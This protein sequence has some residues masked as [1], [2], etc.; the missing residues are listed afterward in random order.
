MATQVINTTFKLKRGIASRWMELNPI[1]MEGEPGFE[2][3]R[4][5]LKIGDGVTAWNDLPYIEGK[6]EF[7]VYAS[8]NDFPAAGDE[9]VLYA[10]EDGIYRY[11]QNEYVLINGSG[12]KHLSV[13][14]VLVEP[15]EGVVAINVPTQIS[16]LTDGE[17]AWL[18]IAAARSVAD[19]GLALATQNA[20]AIAI[21]NGDE[22]VVGSVKS[23]AKAVFDETIAT[24]LDGAPEVMDTLREVSEWIE[25]HEGGLLTLIERVEA[26]EKE[27]AEINDPVFGILAQA[28]QYTDN[29]IAELPAATVESLGLVKIDGD[30]IKTNENNQIYVHRVTTDMIEQG[31]D[32]LVLHAGDSDDM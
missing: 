3:D 14:G 30:T 9:N 1:L 32:M 22:T 5:R 19:S 21:L 12:I 31:S 26:N 29:E 8:K 11:I 25:N 18:E 20:D 15:E 2:M 4:N 7:E 24:I 17:N 23:A 28:M 10:C 27:V 13:N 16:E 6:A